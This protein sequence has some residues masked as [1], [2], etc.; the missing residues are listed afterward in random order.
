MSLHESGEDY[1]ET[2]YLLHQKTPYVRSVDIANELG[3]TKASISRAMRIL[4]EAGLITVAEDGDVRLTKAGLKKAVEVYE[5]HTLITDFFEQF[6]G[7]NEITAEKDACKIEHV[8]SEE[9]YLRLR[10]YM[11]KQGY[12]PKKVKA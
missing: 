2:I 11:T 6:L 10:S 8:I 1:L 3:Y 12:D 9:T 7:V 5:R 4:R